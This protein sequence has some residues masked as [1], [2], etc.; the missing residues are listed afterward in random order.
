MKLV[1]FNP[2]RTIGIPNIQYV[3]PDHMFKE[4]E[5]IKHADFLLFPENWQVNSLV[6]GTKKRIF[7][8]IESIQL[9]YSK[10]EMTRALW[11]VCPENVPY[12]EILG[13]SKESRRKVLETFPFPFVAK[14]IRNS[15]GKGVFLINNEEDFE[16]YA[17]ANDVLYVQE[18]LPID[19]DLRVCVVGEEIIGSYWRIGSNGFHNNVSQGGS[20]SFDQ[21]PEEALELVL[22]IAKAL[23]INHAG[24]DIVAV[25]G[26]YYILEFNV[27]FGNQAFHHLEVSPEKKIYD[28]LLRMENQN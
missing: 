13:N 10:M 1:T 7:P 20:I 24:F 21:I 18:Y 2:F 16:K 14:E 22:Q 27:L 28:Y 4:L 12:T 3:K 9:G 5:K 15:M 8:S 23:N 17:A 25:N 11:T 6:Y 19:R 26:K